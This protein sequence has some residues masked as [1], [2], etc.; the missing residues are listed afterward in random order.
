MPA[1]ETRGIDLEDTELTQKPLGKNYLFAIA[2]DKYQH[3][4]PLSNCVKDARDLI[5]VLTQN[6][7]FDPENLI[8]LF[9]E[10]ATERNINQTFRKLREKIKEGDNLIIYFAGHG[11]IDEDK[12]G[13]LIEGYWIP[14]EAETEAYWDFI[15]TTTIK[16][17][18]DPINSFH[19]VLIVDAC[20]SGAL[21]KT[22]RSTSFG[23][24]N[25]KSRWGLSATH[26]KEKAA[27]GSAGDNSPFAK[28]LL[29]ELKN[30]NQPIGIQKLASSI[31]DR[32]Q[33]A[34]QGKQAPIFKPLNVLGDN[35]GQFVF[36]PRAENTFVDPRDGQ[37]Y[38]TV[39]INGQTWMAE[40]LNY[41]IEDSW[42]FD[43][44]RVLG[45]AYG[46]LYNWESA[47]KACPAGWR[48]PT[49]KDW[50]NLVQ[51]MGGFHD[52][53][54]DKTIGVPKKAYQKLIRGGSTGF[55]AILAGNRRVVEKEVL[56]V[57]LGTFGFYWTA[58]E[59]DIESAWYYYFVYSKNNPKLVRKFIEKHFGFSCRCIRNE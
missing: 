36:H 34:T 39:E 2:I 46:R 41:E 33:R 13:K 51:N 57:R 31:I 27:D 5:T 43:N 32:V 14:V 28:S 3:C 11:E 58:S 8:Q 38:K 4:P 25:R 49:D 19:T 59:K 18:L 56:Y 15:P 52:F 29:L 7:Q 17:L 42:C 45:Q 23:Y 54:I 47:Q 30:N 44:I 20:F 12:D 50:Q 9:D 21:F 40:N 6:Y 10:A 35:S 55:N 16:S 53:E 48:I 24:E 22:E 1:E 26:S 37:V